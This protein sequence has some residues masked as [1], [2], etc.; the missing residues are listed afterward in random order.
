MKRLP[1][2]SIFIGGDRDEGEGV[3]L[4]LLAGAQ[5][6]DNDAAEG[7]GAVLPRRLYVEAADSERL[8]ERLVVM[9]RLGSVIFIHP[10]SINY[11]LN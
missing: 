10:V 9:L 8:V 4:C 2:T 6:L 11:P 7:A 5:Q 1:V 3:S